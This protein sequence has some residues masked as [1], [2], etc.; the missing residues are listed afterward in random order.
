MYLQGIS[1]QKSES[2]LYTKLS[3]WHHQNEAQATPAASILKDH[4]AR[5]TPREAPE[6]A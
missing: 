2:T 5:I 1:K 4:F 3:W 6:S